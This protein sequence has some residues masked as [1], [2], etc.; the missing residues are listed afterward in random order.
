MRMYEVEVYVHDSLIHICQGSGTAEESIIVLSPE[1]IDV[2]CEW[3]K[4]AAESSRSE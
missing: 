3:L 4:G 2:V 1:Q